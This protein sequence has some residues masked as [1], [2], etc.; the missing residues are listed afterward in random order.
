MARLDWECPRC[1]YFWLDR[2]APAGAP[3][4][5]CPACGSPEMIVTYEFGESAGIDLQDVGGRSFEFEYDLD[6]PKRG[7]KVEIRS[8]EDARAV[9]RECER[10][11]ADGA[12][13]PVVFRQFEQGKSNMH[14]NVFGERP[15]EARRRP[16]TRSKSGVPFISRAIPPPT[17]D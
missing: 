14:Q 3:H 10:M 4:P 15:E 7:R 13:R 9:Q 1:D 11:A 16:I 8:M 12:H 6:S 17:E 5:V 2:V